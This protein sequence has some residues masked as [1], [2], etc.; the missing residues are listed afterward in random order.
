M[1]VVSKLTGL[2]FAIALLLLSVSAVHADG[3]NSIPCSQRQV[4]GC[5]LTT[6]DGVNVYFNGWDPSADEGAYY[7]GYRWQCV[8]LIQRYYGEKYNYPG[9][10]APFYAYQTFDSWGHPAT[11]RAYPNGSAT[12][13]QKG[14]V[15]V[16]DQTWDDPYG[17]VALV[18]MV[19]NGRIDFVQQNMY[20]IGEDS[21]P[22]DAHNRI[23]SGGLY[24]PVRG[25]L[26]DITAGLPKASATAT[27]AL[28]ADPT[29]PPVAS[30]NSSQAIVQQASA[31]LEM[32]LQVRFHIAGQGTWEL[33]MDGQSIASGS[34][35]YDSDWVS[36]DVGPHT[37]Q[38]YSATS[39]DLQLTWDA[40]AVQE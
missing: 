13:P 17:H 4:A 23:T 26:R 15:L 12:T 27:S 37:V 32:P 20:A 21:L 10:W 11:M 25:W 9:I 6:L 31:D 40:Q 38:L 2:S 19:S 36:L 22:I 34:D 5:V 18:R 33:E 16:F 3:S 24:G 39:T 29:P 30:A 35:S 7:Y 14:D 1:Y 28:H 8:E